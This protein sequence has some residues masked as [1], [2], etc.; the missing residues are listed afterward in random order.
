MPLQVVNI[1][2][3]ERAVIKD[4]GKLLHGVVVVWEE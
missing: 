3:P 2:P 1:V 4:C